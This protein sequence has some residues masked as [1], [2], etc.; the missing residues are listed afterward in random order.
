MVQSYIITIPKFG[1]KYPI[2]QN[3]IETVK[4]EADRLE[5]EYSVEVLN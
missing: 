1:K 3:N 5:L 2:N 4:E